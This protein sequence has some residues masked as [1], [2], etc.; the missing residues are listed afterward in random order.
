MGEDSII[1]SEWCAWVYMSVFIVI[2]VFFILLRSNRDL[3]EVMQLNYFCAVL[4]FLIAVTFP[5]SCPNSVFTDE[6]AAEGLMRYDL[7]LTPEHSISFPSFRMLCALPVFWYAAKY[8]NR[9]SQGIAFTWLALLAWS[10]VTLGMY[11]YISI[12]GSVVIFVIVM[13]RRSLVKRCLKLANIMANSWYEY[14]F[15]RLRIINHFIYAFLAAAT[16]FIVCVSLAGQD[17]LWST[18][19]VALCALSGAILWG[20]FIERAGKTLRKFG[21]NGAILGSI[22]GIF[23]VTPF[24]PS[25][26]VCNFFGALAVTAPLIKA[27]GRLRCLVQGSCHGRPIDKAY[28]GMGITYIHPDSHVCKSTDWKYVP[29]H[30]TPLYSIAGSLVIF[31]FLI[32]LWN[33]H[34]PIGLIIGFYLILTG[35]LRFVEEAYRGE[36]HRNIH[37]GLTVSQWMCGL[38]VIGGFA[39][40]EI[41]YFMIPAPRSEWS[42]EPIPYA[43]LLGFIYAFFMSCDFPESNRRFSRLTSE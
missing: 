30:P 43:I 17:Y 40:W 8:K 31:W 24:V 6:A 27:I 28:Q 7:M 42:F 21:F 15:N 29:L 34:M 14:R 13:L 9:V 23:L 12:L 41:R 35:F 19:V 4:G 37:H 1:P 32:H 39:V 3:R 5:F 33:L 11:G 36:Q 16:G 2:P 25:L 22:A 26:T 20:L 10:C 18:F 38:F